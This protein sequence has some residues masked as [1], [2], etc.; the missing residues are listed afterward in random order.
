MPLRDHFHQPLSPR[1][2]WN[3][4]HNAWATAIAWDFNRKLPQGFFAEPNVH[5]GIEI[6]VAAW[7]A[8]DEASKKVPALAGAGTGSTETASAGAWAPPSPMQTI[9][10][11][12]TTDVVEVAVYNTEGG[13]SLVGA[14]ELISPANKDRRVHREAFVAKCRSYL[15]DGVGLVLVDIV[16]DR[17]ANLHEDLLAAVGSSPQSAGR[18]PAILY[19]WAYRSVERGN[20][21]EL[22]IW[23]ETLAL[24][25]PLPT[26]PLWLRSGPCLPTDLSGT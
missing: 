7:E 2:H 3:A 14:V 19:A 13:A 8:A 20:Q 11:T 12:L 9:P 24:G 17:Q 10:F 1:R 15:Q 25:G 21:G 5:F 23:F 16:S 26:L 18:A 22:E 6:D 4:F